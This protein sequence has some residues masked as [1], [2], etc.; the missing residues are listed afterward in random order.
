MQQ[1]PT[2]GVVNRRILTLVVALVPIVAFG[3]LLS[4]VAVPFVALGP[5]PTFNTLGEVDGKE[6][7]DI[8]G[9]KVYPTSGHLN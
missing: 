5:G 1:S 9:T 4:A 6:V 3:V 7:V 8:E 2:V